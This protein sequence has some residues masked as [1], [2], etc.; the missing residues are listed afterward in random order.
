[1]ILIKH[2]HLACH[3]YLCFPVTFQYKWPGHMLLTAL[4]LVALV[5]KLVQ[6]VINMSLLT[7]MFRVFIFFE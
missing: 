6:H 7:Y 4:W 2:I 5:Y 1:M 3:C